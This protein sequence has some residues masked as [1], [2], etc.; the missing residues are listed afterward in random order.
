[1]KKEEDDIRIIEQNDHHAVTTTTT[2][3]NDT[4]YRIQGHT[5]KIQHLES[6]IS[7]K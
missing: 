4:K 3:Q 1:M 2:V 6:I 7:E 5:P